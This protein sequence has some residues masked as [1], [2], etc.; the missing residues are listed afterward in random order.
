[1]EGQMD[2]P[3]TRGG[4]TMTHS[5][6]EDRPHRRAEAQSDSE[7]AEVLANQWAQEW[8]YLE[9]VDEV[10][11]VKPVPE[12]RWGEPELLEDDCGD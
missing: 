6:P 2:S 1:M 3:E 8:L 5:D 9:L 7:Y 10:P 4:Q 12:P 11:W